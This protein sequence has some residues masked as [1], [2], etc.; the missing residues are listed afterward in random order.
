MDTQS[1]LGETFLSRVGYELKRAERYRIFVSLIVLDLGFC[2]DLLGDKCAERMP[3]IEELARSNTR[4]IDQVA[5][6]ENDNLALLFPE[7]SR[8]GAEIAARR[9][10]GAIR[11]Y[12]TEVSGQSIGEVIP[13]EMASYPDAAGTKTVAMFLEELLHHKR[14]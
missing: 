3:Q 12:I 5:F 2:R 6:V 4:A 11:N 13:L 9:L 14:N 7:T 10:T 8:Q 1:K